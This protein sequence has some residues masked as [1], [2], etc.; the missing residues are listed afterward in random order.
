MKRLHHYR[1]NTMRPCTVIS[2]P[3]LLPRFH[4]TS[5]LK[6]HPPAWPPSAPLS[7]HHR[8]TYHLAVIQSL[9]SL[10]GWWPA[11]TYAE[12]RADRQTH[13]CTLRF[14]PTQTCTVLHNW[15]RRRITTS[16]SILPATDCVTP[17]DFSATQDS[18]LIS[19]Q[20]ERHCSLKSSDTITATNLSDT[21][22]WCGLLVVL[23]GA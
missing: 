4:L 15:I 6:L 10:S 1:E 18:N 11:H 3:K 5:V 8:T 20:S 16:Q 23:L 14:T 22:V 2:P 12:I 13:T 21:L 7:P 19:L 9:D 17:T